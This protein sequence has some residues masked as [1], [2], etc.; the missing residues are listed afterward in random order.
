MVP[1]R[2]LQRRFQLITF[3]LGA[4]SDPNVITDPSEANVPIVYRVWNRARRLSIA[5]AMAVG[6]GIFG[7]GSW[8]LRALAVE[9]AQDPPISKPIINEPEV[10]MP[11]VTPFVGNSELKARL[12]LPGKLAV[13]GE[14]VHD[15]LLR[16]FYTAHAYQTVWAAHPT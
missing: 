11:E 5:S 12:D 1:T 10:G 9:P 15:Q 16:R 14:R 2:L 7:V 4:F 6:L 8:S 3:R 13:A